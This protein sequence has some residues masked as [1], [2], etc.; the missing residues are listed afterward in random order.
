VTGWEARGNTT[1]SITFVV[2]RAATG[3]S[4]YTNIDGSEPPSLSSASFNSDVSLSTWTTSLSA[5]DTLKIYVTGSPTSIT[6]ASVFI[7][8]SRTIS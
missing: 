1:G 8:L 2:D 4:S 3:S 6:R 5:R 7:R